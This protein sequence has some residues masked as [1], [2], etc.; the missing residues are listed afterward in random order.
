MSFGTGPTVQNSESYQKHLH[1]SRAHDH[2]TMEGQ[3]AA[4]TAAGQQQEC[5]VLWPSEQNSAFKSASIGHQQHAVMPSARS[6][7][8]DAFRTPS[9]FDA[10]YER[11]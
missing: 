3:T 1:P 11:M 4:S 9:K 10:P 5:E 7:Q 2:H 8:T 6:H